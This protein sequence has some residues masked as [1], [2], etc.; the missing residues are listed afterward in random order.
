MMRR[1]GVH[2]LWW[3]PFLLLAS[4]L[5]A[6]FVLGF[7]S[8][9]KQ[10]DFLDTIRIVADAIKESDAPHTWMREIRFN[11]SSMMQQ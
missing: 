3:L 10:N 7:P 11:I 5:D 4:C 9:R 8:V 6:A 1:Y 2:T